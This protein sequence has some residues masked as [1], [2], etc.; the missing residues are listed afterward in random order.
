[1]A[2][3][4]IGL[5]TGAVIALIYLVGRLWLRMLRL[6]GVLDQLEDCWTSLMTECHG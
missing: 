2:A 1:M 3:V 5:L 4:V 6:E